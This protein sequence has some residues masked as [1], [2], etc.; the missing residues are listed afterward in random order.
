[1]KPAFHADQTQDG[2]PAAEHDARARMCQLRQLT[3]DD[4]CT[5]SLGSESNAVP[6]ADESPVKKIGV[7]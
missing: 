7:W 6:P 5:D 3:N 4:P 2:S 1:M